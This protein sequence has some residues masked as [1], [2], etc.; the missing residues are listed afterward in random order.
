M[1]TGTY[2]YNDGSKY[3]GK[4]QNNLRGSYG[5]M[6]LLNG[7][8]YEGAIMFGK[9]HGQ[10]KYSFKDGSIYQG[11]FVNGARSG[12]GKLIDKNFW[13]EG[14]WVDDQMHG[15]GK[16]NDTPVVMRCNQVERVLN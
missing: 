14:Q 13:Y 4:W 2:L 9:K 8:T 6:S 12:F 5:K 7:D 11:N 16:I 3:E 15:E 1:G 10:G